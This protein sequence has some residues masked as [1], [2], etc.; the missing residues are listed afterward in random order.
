VVRTLIATG[1]AVGALGLGAAGCGGSDE[2]GTSATPASQDALAG[3]WRAKLHQQGL[4]PFTV[5][6]T[7]AS[8]AGSSGN[9]VHYT[10]IDCSG[11]WTYLSAAGSSYRFREVIDRG[12]GGK[13]KGVG[14]V[15]LT[16]QSSAD[17]LGYEFRGGGVVSRGTLRRVS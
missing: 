10:G 9:E 15:T 11:H 17:R 12:N 8:P 13:C 6:A 14:V 3:H 2:A 4:P 16:T 5:T 1:L 7:I